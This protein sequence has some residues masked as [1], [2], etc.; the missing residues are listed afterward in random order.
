MKV[1]SGAWVGEYNALEVDNHGIVHIA[2]SGEHAL[3][4]SRF[5]AGKADTVLRL[6]D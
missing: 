6:S 4:Y 3:W 2:Y 1:D 5:P